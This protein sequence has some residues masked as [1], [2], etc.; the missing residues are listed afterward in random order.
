MRWSGEALPKF[1]KGSMMR[2][3]L[4]LNVSHIL[5]MR[6]WDL[7]TKEL[8]GDTLYTL[9]SGE[10]KLSLW[11]ILNIENGEILYGI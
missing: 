6:M 3:S 9:R 11:A 2:H 7:L 4:Y 10:S 8:I 5:N 1:S